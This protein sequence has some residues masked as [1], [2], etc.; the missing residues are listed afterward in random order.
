M[1]LDS[2]LLNSQHYKA[3]IKV[4]RKELHTPQHHGLEA[5]KKEHINYGRPTYIYIY[6][7]I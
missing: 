4:K 5:I 6:I 1:V 7:Y 3:R 2:S